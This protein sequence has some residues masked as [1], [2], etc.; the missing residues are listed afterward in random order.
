MSCARGSSKPPTGYDNF[1]RLS[2][3]QPQE[4]GAKVIGHGRYAI[5]QMAEVALPRELFGRI[6][7]RIARLRSPDPAPC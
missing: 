1:P 2:L 7:E 5:F 6:L 4:I 3:L